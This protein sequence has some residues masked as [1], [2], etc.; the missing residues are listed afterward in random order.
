MI[1]MEGIQRKRKEGK[2]KR[3]TE[4]VAIPDALNK[5]DGD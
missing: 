3:Q 2:S 4:T 1:E 5:S